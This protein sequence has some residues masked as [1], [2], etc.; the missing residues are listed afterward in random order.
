MSNCCMVFFKS[1]SSDLGSAE[2]HLVNYG[3]NVQN[4]SDHLEVENN[5]KLVFKVFLVAESF[6]LEEAKE[7]SS[8]TEYASNMGQCDTR[9]EVI[10]DD[11]DIALDEANSLM[12]VQGALQDASQGYLFTPWNGNIGEPWLG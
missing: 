4:K 11:L 8:N 7:I 6:V 3:F 10:I 5:S 2:K 12:E 1:G 9:F